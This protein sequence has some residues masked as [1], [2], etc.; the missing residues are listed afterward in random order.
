MGSEPKPSADGARPSFGIGV[1][2]RVRPRTVVRRA[3]PVLGRVARRAASFGGR[4]GQSSLRRWDLD[5]AD[6]SGVGQVSVRPPIDYWPW[7]D[8]EDASQSTL[9]ADGIRWRRPVRPTGADGRR[10]RGAGGPDSG[11]SPCRSADDRAARRRHRGRG[12]HRP[13]RHRHPTPRPPRRHPAGPRAADGPAHVDVVAAAAGGPDAGA[14]GGSR[15]GAS[16][17]HAAAGHRGPARPGRRRRDDRRAR[18]LARSVGAGGRPVFA[19]AAPTPH[20][21]GDVAVG[22]GARA[23][24][25]RAG[26]MAR[27]RHGVAAARRRTACVAPGWSG[28]W[29]RSR[30]WRVRGGC[31]SGRGWRWQRPGGG[32]AGAAVDDAVGGGRGVVGGGP[33]AGMVECGDR[34]LGGAVR[35][36][37]R[38]AGDVGATLALGGPPGGRGAVADGC[39]ARR[40]SRRRIDHP[41]RRRPC[42]FAGPWSR[43]PA[44]SWRRVRRHRRSGVVRGGRCCARSALGAETAWVGPTDAPA[45]VDVPGAA[46]RPPGLVVSRSRR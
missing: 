5:R 6:G 2:A 16:H 39:C 38:R 8:Q 35:L 19:T 18:A 27:A 36:A 28:R 30:R 17:G 15:A 40:R 10:S 44:P 31:R 43:P 23:G 41:P 14:G 33:F 32:A 7:Q 4:L 22:V 9:A 13:G 45:G 34:L 1:A 42:R 25:A 11:S 20:P 37:A 12:A 21:T 26:G 46:V 3:A 24:A 29:G